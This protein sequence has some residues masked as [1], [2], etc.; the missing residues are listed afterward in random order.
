MVDSR[1]CGRRGHVIWGCQ[2]K[3]EPL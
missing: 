3:R 2:A 1:L